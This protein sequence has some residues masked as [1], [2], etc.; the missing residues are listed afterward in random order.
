MNRSTTA[1][2]S[3][4]TTGSSRSARPGSAKGADHTVDLEGRTLLPGLIDVHIHMVGGDK[5]I[6]F[7][8]EP[9]VMRTD[10][11][12]TAKAL[13]EGV[14]AARTVLR[15]GFT[16]VRE[17]G[18]RDF[19]DVSLRNAQRSGLIEGPRMLAS[20]PGIFPTG[21]LG[22][23][24]A[25]ETGV[26]S[27]DGAVYR[28]RQMVAQGVD[29]IKIVSADG[30]EQLGKFWTIFPKREEIEAVFAEATRL[31]RV[32]A[33]HAMGS[34]AIEDV[35]RAGADTVEH[36]WYMTE[37]NCRTLIEHDAYLVP[38]VSNI[39]AI[40][41]RG[42]GLNM[43]WAPMIAGEEPEILDRFRMAIELGVKLAAGTDVGGNVSHRY[44][45][46]A[47]EIE[48]YVQC[49]MSPMAAIGTATLEAARA[50]RRD[51]FVGLDR[52]GQAG[53]PGR[54]R[55]RPA[56]RHQPDANR[57]CR[58][59]A[60]RQG[61][62]RRPRAVRRPARTDPQPRGGRMTKPLK[63]LTAARLAG[64]TE[65]E[66]A[67]TDWT[68]T[69]D[70]W[71]GGGQQPA[72]VGQHVVLLQESLLA[73]G[74]ELPRF[75]ADGIY[76]SETTAAVMRLQID[77]GH[78]WPPGQDWEHIGGIAGAN[79]MVHFDMFDPGGTVGNI[80]P[81]ESGVAATSVAFSESPDNPFAGFDATTSPPSLLMGVRTR[82][83]VHVDCEPAGADVTYTVADPAVA[84]VGLIAEGIVVGGERTGT[85]LVRATSGGEV[86][87]ELEVVVKDVREEV[88]NFFFA[89]DS[90]RE[91]D[92]A[93]LLT[94]RLNRVFRRQANVHFT[95]GLVEDVAVAG[96][97]VEGL[98]PFAV[99]EQLNVFCVGGPEPD[100][101]V[102]PSLVF[103]P[104][105]DC[106]D[107]LTVPHGAGHYLGF[108][109]P[110]PAS[111]LMAA[112]G[113]DERRRISR[114]LAEVFNP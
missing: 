25:P 2:S 60:G 27:V 97:D 21:G 20:G 69:K 28:V 71:D 26:D 57:R 88:V 85:T 64:V 54:D 5:S 44:G 30:P 48:I 70:V 95:L 113:G 87:A 53:R 4:R 7:D 6:G 37:E 114:A 55:R 76:G 62:P 15:A 17:L 93:T 12:A 65:L 1:S 32:K 80:T 16:T 50:I 49:G 43:P 91:H 103:L 61:L 66:E 41:R 10:A 75:G 22:A 90:A 8:D 104:D 112:C 109:G 77:A 102:D 98:R 83:R 92:K 99:P 111:G 42:P 105:D 100:E 47:K 58:G 94:L 3:W 81:V 45:D 39:W 84:T 110:H 79:T 52:A 86:L 19:H 82:R 107:G 56:D 74:Y 11:P 38:T 72:S 89:S 31:G 18:G 96:A 63:R 59:R 68:D 106:P 35:T 23:H 36:G 14:A 78:P 46:N 67:F 13:L 33:A 73:M 108:S 51:E 34:E 101:P 29:V 40:V 24:L 9:P